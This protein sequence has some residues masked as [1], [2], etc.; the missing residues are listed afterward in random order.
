MTRISRASAL[1]IRGVSVPIAD[2]QVWLCE[3]GEEFQDEA[4]TK[5]NLN[6]AWAAY[7]A[8]FPLSDLLTMRQTAMRDI[9]GIDRAITDAQFA[10]KLEAVTLRIDRQVLARFEAGEYPA[11]FPGS[12]WWWHGPEESH[13]G[14]VTGEEFDSIT[15]LTD[16]GVLK[17]E[18]R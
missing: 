3:S 18:M 14:P 13:L 11:C 10:E 6:Q 4:V 17:K 9:A 16:K 1:T 8:A 2:Y 5:H 12:R 7:W 15:R